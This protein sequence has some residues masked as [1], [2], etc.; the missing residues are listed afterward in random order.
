MHEDK[1]F[2]GI[3]RG[4]CVDNQDP[5]GAYK[6]TV[7]VPQLL[8]TATT[9]WALP[10]TP[11]TDNGTH[12]AHTDTITSNSAT[13]STFGGHTHTVTLNSTHSAHIAVPN[14][15]QQVWIMFIAGDPNF[16]VWMG[17]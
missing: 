10:C 2:Y 1:R 12:D 5:D 6:I 17:V 13:V 15:G 11:V 4:I 9:S 7:Q 3:Y 16:P 14:I 8:G